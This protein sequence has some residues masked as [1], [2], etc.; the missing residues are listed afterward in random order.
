MELGL[1]R[2][3]V[4]LFGSNPCVSVVLHHLLKELPTEI[5]G[6]YAVEILHLIEFSNDKSY[7][8][9]SLSDY[10]IIHKHSRTSQDLIFND[11]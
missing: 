7:D 10:Y 9:V 11:M 1:G 2:N 5:V 4:E 3:Q 8:Q 6:S